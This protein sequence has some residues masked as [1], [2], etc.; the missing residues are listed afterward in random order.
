[1]EIPSF[2]H[3]PQEKPDFTYDATD[4]EASI[5]LPNY[6]RMWLT[7][8]LLDDGEV[9]SVVTGTNEEDEHVIIEL[10]AS[11]TDREVIKVT[12]DSEVVYCVTKH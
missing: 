5:E 1:M 6:P 11:G 9:L 10:V 2:E 3:S 7:G 8:V 12:V 4:A